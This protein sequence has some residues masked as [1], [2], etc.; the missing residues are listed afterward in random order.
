M[1]GDNAKYW[2]HKHQLQVNL[3]ARVRRLRIDLEVEKDPV[4]ANVTNTPCVI[5]A[6]NTLCSG[7]TGVW[8]RLVRSRLQR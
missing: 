4:A 3:A 7:G 2:E 6:G 1:V 5:G 8:L